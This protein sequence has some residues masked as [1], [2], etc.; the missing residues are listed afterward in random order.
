MVN[1]CSEVMLEQSNTF[2]TANSA[3]AANTIATVLFPCG[4]RR[5][6]SRFA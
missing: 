4:F 1:Q 5:V 3:A 6:V 2:T